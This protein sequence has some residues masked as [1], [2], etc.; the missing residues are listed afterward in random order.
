VRLPGEIHR[1]PA[2][3]FLIATARHLGVPLMTIDE[4]ILA[5][6]AAG[7]VQTVDASR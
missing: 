5:Y 1:D 3:R 6:G 2:D 4:R 7:H